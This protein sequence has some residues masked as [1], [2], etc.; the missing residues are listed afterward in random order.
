MG[1]LWALDVE[2]HAEHFDGACP[3]HSDLLW[4]PSRAVEGEEFLR[5]GG[6]SVPPPEYREAEFRHGDLHVKAEREGRDDVRL[7]LKACK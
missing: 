3:F 7:A 2:G 6:E 5:R 1:R 4:G